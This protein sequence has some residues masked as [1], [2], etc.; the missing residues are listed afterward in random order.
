MVAHRLS[1]IKDCDRIV[2]FQNGNI[3]EEGNYDELMGKNAAFA[4]LVKK[5]QLER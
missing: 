1:T 3:V 4:R 5:Q 2:V